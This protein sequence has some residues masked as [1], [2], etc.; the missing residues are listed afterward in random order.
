MAWRSETENRILVKARSLNYF[1]LIIHVKTMFWH[2]DIWT[3]YYQQ[4][5]GRLRWWHL[6]LGVVRKTLW[7]V[8]VNAM[9]LEDNYVFSWSIL[10]TVVFSIRRISFMQY[11]GSTSLCCRNMRILTPPQLNINLY[12]PT[13]QHCMVFNIGKAARLPNV[14]SLVKPCRR[15]CYCFSSPSTR[16]EAHSTNCHNKWLKQCGMA[17]WNTFWSLIANLSQAL[18]KGLSNSPKPNASGLI[19]MEQDKQVEKVK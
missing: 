18:F 14:A 8:T 2:R 9:A 11:Y 4:I 5:A 12:R 6:V 15:F 13:D 7:S 19:Y 3:V 17:Q 10:L 16:V 1:H